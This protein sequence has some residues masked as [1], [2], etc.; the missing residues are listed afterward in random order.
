MPNRFKVGDHI[1]LVQNPDPWRV[2]DYVKSIGYNARGVIIGITVQEYLRIRWV[3]PLA[4]GEKEGTYSGQDR[5][6]L[7]TP[8]FDPKLP[9]RQ[10]CGRLAEIVEVVAARIEGNATTLYRARV[11]MPDGQFREL[12][13]SEY[14]Y[15]YK[16]IPSDI[17]QV[18]V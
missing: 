16:T 3:Q 9:L 10:R 1:K 13:Y 11:Q 14:G 5:F 7:D 2:F 15:F 18:N 12:S 8:S 4:D 6:E 17:D